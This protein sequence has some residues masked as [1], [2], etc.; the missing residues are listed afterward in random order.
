VKEPLAAFDCFPP[1]LEWS[2]VPA[3]ALPADHPQ[4]P[5]TLV[6]RQT[7]PDRERFHNLV[8]A[9]GLVAEQ[10]RGIHRAS[11]LT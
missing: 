4:S 11:I 3:G 7:P 6:E 1:F 8:S 5:S 10:A 9:E 2:Q